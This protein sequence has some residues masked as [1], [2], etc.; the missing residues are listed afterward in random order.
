MLD[1][2]FRQEALDAYSERWLGEASSWQGVRPIPLA[3]TGCSALAG[4]LGILLLGVHTREVSLEGVIK[5][6]GIEVALHDARAHLLTV[7][8]SVGFDVK[9]QDGTIEHLRA[10]MA[11]I[12][13][14]EEGDK[15]LYR[16]SLRAPSNFRPGENKSIVVR[17]PLERRRIFEWMVCSLN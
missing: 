15:S 14:A 11:S 17:I 4:L 8:D 1:E 9:G 13:P 3:V 5:G 16:I 12:M 6:T 2:L 7:G 10:Q